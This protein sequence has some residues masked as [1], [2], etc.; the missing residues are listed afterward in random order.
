MKSTLFAGVAA[1][2]LLVGSAAP[3]HAML[4][5]TVS[6]GTTTDTV[7]DLSNSGGATFMGAIGAFNFNVVTGT[8][9]PL[10]GSA[11]LPTLDLNSIDITSRGGSGGTLTFKLT[12][13]DY[14][15]VPGTTHFY[16]AVGGTLTG[17]GS[18]F[19]VK[20]FMDCSNTAFGT[21]TAL[22]SETF[23]GSAFSGS[24][25]AYVASCG[26]HYSLTQLATLTLPGSAMYSGDSN[27]SVPEPSTIALFG[28]GLLG[29]GF[30]LR[31]KGT[32]T[33]AA[34]A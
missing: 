33:P 20:T 5:L 19:Q 2:A 3:S 15:G 24:Q 7:N 30:A 17:V 13:T 4:M 18:S 11:A 14:I 23:T 25:D 21:T 16:D 6:D 8:S 27:L 29:L 22:T 1:A 9:M 32:A 34:A 12:D 10:I 26:G 28:A 31:R